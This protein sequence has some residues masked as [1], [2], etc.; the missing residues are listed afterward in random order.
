M[1]LM[2]EYNA[3]LSYAEFRRNVVSD[4]PDDIDL[5]VCDFNNDE[6][7]MILSCLPAVR[8]SLISIYDS[9]IDYSKNHYMTQKVIATLYQKGGIM[10]VR[11]DAQNYLNTIFEML[12]YF[13]KNGDY[14]YEKAT[15]TIN[16]DVISFMRK[17]THYKPSLLCH[18]EHICRIET[19]KNNR[20]CQMKNFDT[21]VLNFDNKAVC[22]T[23]LFLLL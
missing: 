5:S 1:L 3:L 8:E 13:M 6:R 17:N 18:L 10:T 12:Y 23:L 9:V 20:I 21:I 2:N 15:V 19:Y 4:V 11:R 22:F 14:N 7:K 16:K